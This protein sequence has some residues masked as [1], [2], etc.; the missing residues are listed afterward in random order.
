MT[1][2]WLLNQYPH[3]FLS[4]SF[5]FFFFQEHP[6]CAGCSRRANSHHPTS[7]QPPDSFSRSRRQMA[8]GGEQNTSVGRSTQHL[9]ECAQLSSILTALSSCVC[10]LTTSVF[11]SIF[12]GETSKKRGRENLNKLNVTSQS[13]YK[14]VSGDD[15]E[16]NSENTMT[17]T[18][19]PYFFR[20]FPVS[21][22][23]S[24]CILAKLEILQN[25]FLVYPL[26][27]GPQSP[28]KCCCFFVTSQNPPL[29]SCFFILSR[30]LL[31]G[32][33][34]VCVASSIGPYTS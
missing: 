20:I 11:G 8:S 6:G 26:F 21:T 2:P 1:V 17:F 34:Y 7:H 13:N 30:V 15:L 5:L 16:I 10:L 27:R 22:L 14:S 28:S 29:R 31:F 3:H 9:M 23:R 18:T 24:H 4:E 33:V 19:D 25:R 32:Y 12:I